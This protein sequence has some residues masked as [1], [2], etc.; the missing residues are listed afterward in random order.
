VGVFFSR[1]SYLQEFS[2]VDEREALAV[3]GPLEDSR[4]VTAYA[5]GAACCW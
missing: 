3:E 1:M 5:G 2:R 4:G